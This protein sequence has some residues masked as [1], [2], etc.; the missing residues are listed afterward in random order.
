MD[1]NRALTKCIAVA[2]ISPLYLYLLFI[3]ALGRVPASVSA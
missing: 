1:R 2:L 3:W